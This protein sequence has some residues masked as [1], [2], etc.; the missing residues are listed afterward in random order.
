MTDLK[1]SLALRLEEARKESGFK[2]LR[3]FWRAVAA[4][5]YK[6]SYPAI[7]NYHGRRQE[8]REPPIS[9]LLRVSEVTGVRLEW[10]A[11]G[12]GPM[13]TTG[14]GGLATVL[15]GIT[16]DDGR[17][18]DL[19]D[20][21]LGGRGAEILPKAFRDRLPDQ[22]ARELSAEAILSLQRVCAH[23]SSEDMDNT[24]GQLGQ[25]ATHL[26]LLPSALL[27]FKYH[28]HLSSQEYTDYVL[29]VSGVLMQAVRM[30]AEGKRT[31]GQAR[32]QGEGDQT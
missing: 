29:T 2:D 18:V 1:R 22:I 5:G 31:A 28:R 11:T 21:L 16:L 24:L 8:K 23:A 32:Q 30:A 9:Y 3:A 6:V 13:A 4:E 25:Y 26:L 10:L 20:F 14:L 7:L 27:R 17:T 15:A 19:L 12:Q